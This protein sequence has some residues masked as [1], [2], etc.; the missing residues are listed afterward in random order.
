LPEEHDIVILALL[1]IP[2]GKSR[3]RSNLYVQCGVLCVLIRTAWRPLLSILLYKV[4]HEALLTVIAQYSCRK[5][6]K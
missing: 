2:H 3:Y 6:S 4:T 5:S 1:Q